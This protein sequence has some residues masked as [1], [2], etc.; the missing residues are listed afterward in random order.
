MLLKG[1]IEEIAEQAERILT[2]I[3][4]DAY[5]APQ[6][7]DNRIDCL[8]RLKDGRVIG[9]MIGLDD[10][11]EKRI[12]EAGER[13]KQRSLGLDIALVNELRPPIQIGPSSKFDPGDR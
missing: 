8:I 2:A 5:C 1:T 12:Q 9:E 4:E 11:E 10:A 6:E 13:L 3:V 7:W